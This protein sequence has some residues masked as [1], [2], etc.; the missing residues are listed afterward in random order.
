[1]T[2]L[3]TRTKIECVSR[4]SCPDIDSSCL[5]SIRI[6][7]DIVDIS[8]AWDP[9]KSERY[10]SI[11]D[12]IR[13]RRWSFLSYASTGVESLTDINNQTDKMITSKE[14]ND[15]D[16]GKTF[17]LTILSVC[18]L[19][20]ICILLGIVVNIVATGTKNTDESTSV[21]SVLEMAI[22]GELHKDSS[23]ADLELVP[24]APANIQ[25]I[26]LMA[27]PIEDE[28]SKCEDICHSAECCTDPNASDNCFRE[29]SKNCIQHSIC[30]E[31]NFNVADV[32]AILVN[33]VCSSQ[34]LT[35]QSGINSCR[36]ACSEALCCYPEKYG[37]NLENTCKAERN[38]DKCNLFLACAALPEI[39]G[40]D[41]ESRRL[42]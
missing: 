19:L 18:T 41:G 23:L 37:K 29:N 38:A 1:M 20:S 3:Y 39:D 36:A 42:H 13:D 16:G 26:C 8:L 5:S 7:D 27:N 9:S 17:F 40:N 10:E 24:T 25:E 32:K 33:E 11:D 31:R 4:S 34:A 6:N 35:K 2:R 15:V 28:F 12:H 14:E 30:F 21:T 22:D